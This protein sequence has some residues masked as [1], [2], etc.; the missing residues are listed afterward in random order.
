MD[1]WIASITG[2]FAV[3]P[4]EK[5]AFLHKQDASFVFFFSLKIS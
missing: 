4:G 1:C 3:F 2:T 5:E